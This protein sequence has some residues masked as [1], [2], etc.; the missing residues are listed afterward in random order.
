[1]LIFNHN[2]MC[3]HKPW[4]MPSQHILKFL[5]T[6]CIIQCLFKIPAQRM[7]I[8]IPAQRLHILKK[9][10]PP[11]HSLKICITSHFSVHFGHSSVKDSALHLSHSFMVIIYRKC[12]LFKL[13]LHLSVDFLHLLE[14]F[15]V[16]LW[17][18]SFT[19]EEFFETIKFIT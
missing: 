9:L 1:M 6:D 5:Q 4:K 3:K 15:L 10:S 13:C 14:D 17:I 16:F 2:K 11:D 18:M 19:S 12:W 8:Q 7:H